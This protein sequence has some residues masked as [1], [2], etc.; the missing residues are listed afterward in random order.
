MS[1]RPISSH[2]HY[3]YPPTTSIFASSL[4]QFEAPLPREGKFQS[5]FARCLNMPSMAMDQLS[6]LENELLDTRQVKWYKRIHIFCD[7]I[8]SP[9]QRLIQTEADLMRLEEVHS[10]LF[11]EHKNLQEDYERIH[12]YVEVMLTQHKSCLLTYL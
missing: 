10:S 2:S 5:S 8:Y 7:A 4:Q 9:F 6:W 1:E 12:V 3:L 11:R